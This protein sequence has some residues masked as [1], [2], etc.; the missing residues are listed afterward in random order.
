M[1]LDAESRRCD[2]ACAFDNMAVSIMQEGMLTFCH[3]S[4]EVWSPTDTWVLHKG[5][6]EIYGL[7]SLRFIRVNLQQ[8]V[9]SAGTPSVSGSQLVL[10]EVFPSPHSQMCLI[11][12]VDNDRSDL[13][14]R[15]SFFVAILG[16]HN[17]SQYVKERMYHYHYDFDERL[18]WKI[19][20]IPQRQVKN[21]II[22]CEVFMSTCTC[23]DM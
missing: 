21:Q 12:S 22:L 2:S 11:N 16:D 19:A 4:K 14:G 17:L 23:Q 15:I 18:F 6:K 8:V 3:F 13:H 20:W 5:S 10:K 7:D 1:Q 9:S